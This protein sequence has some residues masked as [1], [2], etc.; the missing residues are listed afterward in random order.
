M[1]LGTALDQATETFLSEN[2]SPSRKVGEL[3]T[4]GS[5]FYLALYW[6]EA[7]ASQTAE[8][9]LSAK[10]IPTAAALREKAD[11]ILGTLLQVQGSPQDIGGYYLPDPEKVNRAMRPSGDFNAILE[12]LS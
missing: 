3:D 8:K 6:A 11:A 7:L 9:E 5:H 2:R 10:F 12:K 1:A 4:R